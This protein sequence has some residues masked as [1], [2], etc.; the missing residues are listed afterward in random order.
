VYM[1]LFKH[2]FDIEYTTQEYNYD[3]DR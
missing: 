2:F 1:I 3:T